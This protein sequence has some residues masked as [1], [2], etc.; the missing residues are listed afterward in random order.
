MT[1][2]FECSDKLLYVLSK[3]QDEKFININDL[4]EEAILQYY[5]ISIV[6]LNNSNINK[7][8]SYNKVVSALNNSRTIK[9][10]ANEL[11]VSER[12]IYRKIKEMSIEFDEYNNLYLI[13]K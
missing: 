8:T 2:G 6:D 7:L 5:N 4:I 13:K 3:L 12:T 1:I 9:E 11:G 10:A